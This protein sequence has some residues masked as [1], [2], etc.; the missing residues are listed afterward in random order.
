M[1]RRLA[2]VFLSLGYLTAV[3]AQQADKPE[4]TIEKFSYA[5]GYRMAQDL[6]R[7]NMTLIDAPSL[8]AGIENALKGEPLGLSPEDM[9][10]VVTAYQQL[11]MQKTAKLA[12]Q[13]Q[14]AGEAFM[15]ANKGKEGVQ[16]FDNAIQYRILTE[17]TGAKPNSDDTV[18]V[19]YVGR[20]LDG[21]IFDSSRQRDAPSEFKL[22]G[23][24][25][26]WTETLQQMP[27]GSR[28]LVWIPPEMAYGTRGAG[29]KIGPNMTLEFEIELLEVLPTKQ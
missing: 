9:Q 16:I 5:M 27:T 20:L 7:Q 2:V 6:A 15:Q 22:D 10:Q 3:P 12:D 23:V 21:Q 29:G 1:L 17:G 28:W 14:Q 11:V 26:G 18:K 8:A 19:H 24:I 25:K 4:T 13:N